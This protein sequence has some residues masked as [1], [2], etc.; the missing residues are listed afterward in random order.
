MN[1]KS[2]NAQKSG[3]GAQENVHR[4]DPASSTD[5]AVASGKRAEDG[6]QRTPVK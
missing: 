5:Y 4:G 1:E 3:H 2:N 6:G